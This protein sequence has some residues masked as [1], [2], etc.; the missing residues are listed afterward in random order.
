[1][2]FVIRYTLSL[3]LVM[4]IGYMI[5]CVHMH[6]Y[7]YVC[8]CL[9]LLWTSVPLKYVG[10][11]CI[12]LPFLSIVRVS[13][14]LS[15]GEA[16]LDLIYSLMSVVI[17]QFVFCA[18]LDLCVCVGG[19]KYSLQVK[20]TVIYVISFLSWTGH[21]NY[22]KTHFFCNNKT[23]YNPFFAHIWTVKCELL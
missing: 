18:H 23:I 3:T 22:H 19:E 7:M 8:M 6:E 9:H 1:M 17:L 16:H 15:E 5:T 12:G 11:K 4:C 21:S 14:T 10:T 20:R 2:P 13:I